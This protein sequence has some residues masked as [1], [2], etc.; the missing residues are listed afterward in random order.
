MYS[1]QDTTAKEYLLLRTQLQ[2]DWSKNL[3]AAVSTIEN[4]LRLYPDDK[5]VQLFA[6]RLASLSYT[7]IA[8]KSAEEYADAV[9]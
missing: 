8:G 7:K 9:L 5:D 3:N 4:A 1:R 2:Y 6:A